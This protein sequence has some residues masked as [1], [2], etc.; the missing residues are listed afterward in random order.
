LADRWESDMHAVSIKGRIAV[1]CLVCCGVGLGGWVLFRDRAGATVLAPSI[2]AFSAFGGESRGSP[3]DQAV[4]SLVATLRQDSQDDGAWARLGDALMQKARETMDGGY[5]GRAELAFQ[6]ALALDGTSV[7]AMTGLAWVAGA[8]H[9]FER[10]I[11]WAEKAIAHD[12]DSHAAYGLLG[13]AAVEMGDY[14]AGFRHYQR[15]LDIRPDLSSFSRGA[16]LLFL[17]GDTRTAISLMHKAI[18]AGAPHAENTN[19]CRAQ[20][21]L[22]LLKTGALMPA[23]QG[24]DAALRDA[25][26]NYH[27]LVAMGAVKVAQRDYAAAVEHYQQAIA[28][29]PQHEAVVALGDLYALTGRPEDAEAQYALVEVIQQTNKANG[30]RGTL[31]LARFY[32]DHDRNLSEALAIAEDEYEQRPNLFAADTLAWCYYK[33]GRYDDA[34]RMIQRALSRQTPEATFHFHAGMIHARLGDRP[35]ARQHL[36][37]ALSLNPHF[38]PV[39]APAA[40]DML[41]QLGG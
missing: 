25:P 1:L 19:W 24:L 20:V 9:E 5:Y 7:D 14:E 22:M 36:Y 33:N 32:A 8:R 17:T 34:R 27:L 4:A 38:H 11:Q 10:S 31:E 41:K 40:A 21:A 13:D 18:A 26:A 37:Q 15:M 12:P 28:I 3:T 30:V 29:A 16:H 39:D 2:E 23:Q 6:N 35:A